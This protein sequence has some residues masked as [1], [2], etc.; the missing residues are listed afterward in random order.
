MGTV[1]QIVDLLS[2]P[3]FWVGL[4]VGL[5]MLIAYYCFAAWVGSMDMPDEHSTKEYRRKFKFF[6]L[7]AANLKRAARTARIPINGTKVMTQE[8]IDQMK[9]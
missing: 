5:T 6:N 4:G 7:L 3:M 9:S 1:I 2:K 8:E